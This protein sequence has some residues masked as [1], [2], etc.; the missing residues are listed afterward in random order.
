MNLSC[1][2]DSKV[3][4]YDV[5]ERIES[6]SQLKV[7]VELIIDVGKYDVKERIESKSQLNQQ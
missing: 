7:W 2:I 3:G 5:K 1:E 4:K 6:K